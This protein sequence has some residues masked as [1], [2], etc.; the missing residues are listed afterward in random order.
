MYSLKV[1]RVVQLIKI[2]QGPKL[3]ELL[4]RMFLVV[5]PQ[6]KKVPG[7][8]CINTQMTQPTITCNTSAHN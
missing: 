4:L 3:T 5:I 6:R 2:T 7:G 1:R 8:C